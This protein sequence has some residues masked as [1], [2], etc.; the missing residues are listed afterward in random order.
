MFAWL[1]NPF[2]DRGEPPAAHRHLDSSKTGLGTPNKTAHRQTSVQRVKEIKVSTCPDSWSC[3]EISD[4]ADP[5]AANL[6]G[7]SGEHSEQAGRA[8]LAQAS[9]WEILRVSQAASGSKLRGTTASK[10]GE[11]L[12]RPPSPQMGRHKCHVRVQRCSEHAGQLRYAPK[13]LVLADLA[14]GQKT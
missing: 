6:G 1:V 7:Y 4:L 2:G 14:V 3:N 9:V 13:R 10:S 5:P 12:E 11:P 8:A